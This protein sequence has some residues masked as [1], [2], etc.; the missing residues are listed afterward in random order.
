MLSPIAT[1]ILALAFLA[2]GIGIAEYYHYRIDKAAQ[3]K[4][5]EMWDLTP[6]PQLKA[7]D[8]ARQKRASGR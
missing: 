3:G 1:V 5:Q 8:Y 4:P 7:L 2:I 6:A